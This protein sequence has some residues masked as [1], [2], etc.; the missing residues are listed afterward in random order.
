MH[1]DIVA[2]YEVSKTSL[3]RPAAEEATHSAKKLNLV[4][5]QSLDS[6]FN[7][8]QVAGASITKDG[9][10]KRLVSFIASALLPLST[11]DNEEF[12]DFVSCKYIYVAL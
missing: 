3:K 5:Q 11:V 1:P 12:K 8:P 10:T 7:K 2:E 9:L 6:L 4:K